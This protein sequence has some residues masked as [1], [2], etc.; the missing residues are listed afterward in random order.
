M[1]TA[2][3]RVLAI[4][5]RVQRFGFV[6]FEYPNVLLDWGVSGYHASVPEALDRKIAYCADKFAPVVVLCREH[7][8]GSERQRTVLNRRIKI[9]RE[10][11]ERRSIPVRLVSASVIRKHFQEQGRNNKDEVSQIVVTYFPEL[12][13]RLPA[14]RRP[15][16]SE[17]LSQVLFDAAALAV[18]HSACN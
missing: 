4:E 5:L 13:W 11:A 16:Q 7:I 3:E 10:Q 15:W 2:T 17:P 9:L 12:A 1:D 8:G 6:L 18:F 14:K